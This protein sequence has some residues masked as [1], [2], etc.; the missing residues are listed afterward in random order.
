MSLS[1]LK[2][3]E[4]E[5]HALEHNALRLSG[6]Q[7]LLAE[8]R[9]RDRTMGEFILEVMSYW[10]SGSQGVARE[11][12]FGVLAELQFDIFRIAEMRLAAKA[13]EHK[14]SAAQKRA[15]ITTAILPLPSETTHEIS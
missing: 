2:Q 13:R 14:V 1:E 8:E 11:E 3:L 4:A 7:G 5:V 15:I 10:H 12:L 9:K 6:A